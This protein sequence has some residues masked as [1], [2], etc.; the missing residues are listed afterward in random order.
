MTPN[1]QGG[2]G[3]KFMAA[4]DMKTMYQGLAKEIFA[5]GRKSLDCYILN[6]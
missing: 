4:N 1:R 5:D 3:A 6:I 2:G